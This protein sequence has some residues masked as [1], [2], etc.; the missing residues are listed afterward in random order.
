[1]G[2]VMNESSRQIVCT[3][4]RKKQFVICSLWEEFINDPI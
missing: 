2:V 3:M 4:E 1:M